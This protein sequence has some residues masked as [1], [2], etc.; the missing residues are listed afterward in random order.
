MMN[1][2]QRNRI[3]LENFFIIEHVF[4]STVVEDI[5]YNNVFM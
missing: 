4:R 2:I 5:G 3:I 1:V